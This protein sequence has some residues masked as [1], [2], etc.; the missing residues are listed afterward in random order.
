MT[1]FEVFLCVGAQYKSTMSTKVE[2][3]IGVN[4]QEFG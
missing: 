2:K 4:D 3:F 1:T